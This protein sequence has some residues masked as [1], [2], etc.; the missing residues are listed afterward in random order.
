M[1]FKLRKFRNNKNGSG[2]LLIIIPFIISIILTAVFVPLG[3]RNDFK[4]L[5]FYLPENYQ[6]MSVLD[7]T[8]WFVEQHGGQPIEFIKWWE[9]GF[10]SD[11]ILER[12]Y[13]FPDGFEISVEDFLEYKLGNV[14]SPDF[15]EVALSVLTLNPYG[16]DYLGNY[17]MLIRIILIFV[18]CI[19][20]VDILWFG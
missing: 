18:L 6:N 8:E 17:G 13:R 16:L 14:G 11:P 3:E 15:V 9:F 19:G 10:D 20:L 7:R 2:T 12:Y 1:A 4:D 5:S